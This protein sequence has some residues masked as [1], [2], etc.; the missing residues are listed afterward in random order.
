MVSKMKMIFRIIFLLFISI[1]FSKSTYAGQSDEF[2]D[3]IVFVKSCVQ[4]YHQMNQV[5][6]DSEYFD[7]EVF[8]DDIDLEQI[9]S[10]AIGLVG[11]IKPKD[12][13]ILQ[14][15][16]FNRNLSKIAINFIF[17]L[18]D[19]IGLNFVFYEKDCKFFIYDIK[20]YFLI[21]FPEYIVYKDLSKLVIDLK[22]GVP[23]KA[24]LEYFNDSLVVKCPKNYG[25]KYYINEVK[26]DY[27]RDKIIKQEIGRASCRERV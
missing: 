17:K 4:N 6:K 3:I 19:E 9:T 16:D 10:L 15:A 20:P 24:I 18:N 11:E 21:D 23:T 2:D 12:T 1:N 8:E 25:S 26:L 5:I 7:D 27:L 13:I 14:K 22:N